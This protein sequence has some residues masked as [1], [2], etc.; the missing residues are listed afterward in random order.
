[1]YQ[2]L[3]LCIFIQI[4]CFLSRPFSLVFCEHFSVE[5][6]LYLITYNRLY[7]IDI[8][9][10]RMKDINWSALLFITL[11]DRNRGKCY[12]W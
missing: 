7:K 1:M 10:T 9:L 2:Y 3:Y 12:I 6:L 4:K 5:L 8:I 11:E